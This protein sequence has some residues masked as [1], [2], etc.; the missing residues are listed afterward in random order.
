MI[1]IYNTS[2]HNTPI[3]LHYNSSKSYI[4]GYAREVK[5]ATYHFLNN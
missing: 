4:H 2:I 1:L 5:N 3:T